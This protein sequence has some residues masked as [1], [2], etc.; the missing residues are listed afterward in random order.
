MKKQF[1]RICTLAASMCILFSGCA[2]GSLASNS[3]SRTRPEGLNELQFALPQEGDPIAVISTSMGDISIILYP[4]LAPMAVE[5]FTGLAQN[6]YYNGVSFHRVVEGFLIQSGDSTK[7]GCGGDSI[8]NGKDFPNEIS[9]QLHHYSGA[10]AFAHPRSGSAGNLSQF[11]IVQSAQNSVDSQIGD[12][13]L[14]NGVRQEVVDA[15]RAV[16]GVPYL[17]NLDTVFA[18]VYSGM[19][20]VDAIASVD[21]GDDETPEQEIT[22]SSITIG[23]YSSAQDAAE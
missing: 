3:K 17:D 1:L 2:D 15:Y 7:T 11:Y 12:T 6:G 9:D 21:C 13:L 5:N 8:W 16:G 18:Q 4:E 19:E 14:N 23:T 10:V 22:I 20:V